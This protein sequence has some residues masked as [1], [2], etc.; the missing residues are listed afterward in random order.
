MNFRNT[1]NPRLRNNQLIM[2]RKMMESDAQDLYEVLSDP[3]VIAHHTYTLIDYSHA[4]EYIRKD[5]LWV[6]GK[7]SVTSWKYR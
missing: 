1:S 5:G 3:D 4:Y 2:I 7:N 6:R